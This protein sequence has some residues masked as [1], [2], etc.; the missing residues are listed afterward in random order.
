VTSGSS[1]EVAERRA[2]HARIGIFDLL[3]ETGA[4]TAVPSLSTSTM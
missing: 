1:D 3:R 2:H 4:L